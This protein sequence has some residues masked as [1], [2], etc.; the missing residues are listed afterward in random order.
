MGASVKSDF[1][2]TM[3][4]IVRFHGS[5]ADKHR[6]KAESERSWLLQCC[7]LYAAVSLVN[8]KYCKQPLST[9]LRFVRVTTPVP[10]TQL[11]I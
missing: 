7:L 2:P 8:T 11:Q 3:G 6:A 9:L 1:L 4:V 5:P 10:I